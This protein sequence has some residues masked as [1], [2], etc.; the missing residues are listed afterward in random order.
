MDLDLELETLK[1]IESLILMN[2]KHC[3]I[4]LRDD[5][6]VGNIKYWITFIKNAV[7]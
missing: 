2:W 7:I 5:T 3:F 4:L 1:P 6:W